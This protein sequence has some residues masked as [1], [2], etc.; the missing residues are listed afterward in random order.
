MVPSLLALEG[1]TLECCEQKLR[2]TAG[3]RCIPSTHHAS[4]DMGQ[5]AFSFIWAMTS[6]GMGFSCL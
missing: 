6:Q 2:S 5:R 4:Q 3:K 1:A